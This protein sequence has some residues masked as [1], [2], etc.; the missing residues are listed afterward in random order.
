MFSLLKA[1]VFD[2]GQEYNWAEF[3]KPSLLFRRKTN[4]C[5]NFYLLFICFFICRNFYYFLLLLRSSLSASAFQPT[6]VSF[7]AI[8]YLSKSSLVLFAF[9]LVG[10]LFVFVFV[11][12]LHPSL[13]VFNEM[14]NCSAYVSS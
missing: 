9:F 6:F 14:K 11:F 10:W 2:S 3:Q 12:F 1:D 7:V 13:H 8:D 4:H 5:R